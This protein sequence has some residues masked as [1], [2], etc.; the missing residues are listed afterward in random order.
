VS[1]SYPR[2]N[3]TLGVVLSLALFLTG[4]G[5]PFH[6]L[7]EPG[8]AEIWVDGKFRGVGGATIPTNGIVFNSYHVEA[9]GDEGKVLAAEDV[10][11]TF[12]P[13]SAV[14]TILGLAGILIW[15]LLPFL[16]LA[17][18]V[19]EPSPEH[20]YLRVEAPPPPPL[21]Q[22]DQIDRPVLELT[23]PTP[24]ARIE[25]GSTLLVRGR[26][27][28][29]SGVASVRVLVDGVEA[30]AAP[31]RPDSQ[32]E[33]SFALNV[34]LNGHGEHMIRVV[35][36]GARG[37]EAAEEVRVDYLLK[38]GAPLPP[39]TAVPGLEPLEKEK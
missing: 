14:F 16:P 13:R 32:V 4:C 18:F 39:P 5:Q 21:P 37:S 20:L 1:R 30:A 3:A 36:R 10:D 31:P 8:Q 26:A 17:F 22:L 27:R 38:G 35:A 19:G 9:R 6:V 2:A 28:H 11:L 7:T 29:W 25:G 15:P 23:S 24:G 34:T 12:G 33:V